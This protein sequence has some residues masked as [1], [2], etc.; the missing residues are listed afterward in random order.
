MRQGFSLVSQRRLSMKHYIGS[1]LVILICCGS[2][3]AQYSEE[4]SNCIKRAGTQAKINMCAGEEARSAD[5]LLND[6]YHKLL[7]AAAG[8]AVRIEKIRAIE[9]A[10]ISY[11]DAYISAVYPAKDK[12]AAYGSIFPTQVDLLRTRLTR[13][14]IEALKN[15]QKAVESN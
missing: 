1:A 11:R 13:Q 10:W 14:Q 15:L 8:Q 6:I 4:Y 9:R 5:A 12:Q 3:F 7:S 2:S